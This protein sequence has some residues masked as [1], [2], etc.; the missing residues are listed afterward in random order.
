MS[1]ELG[2]VSINIDELSLPKDNIVSIILEGPDGFQE[3][4]SD[5][6]VVSDGILV[7]SINSSSSATISLYLYFNG[8]D[9]NC[10][11]IKILSFQRST[12]EFNIKLNVKENK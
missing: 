8:N 5:G 11:T 1:E 10:T 2:D 12:G 4:I 7:S 9:E 3:M 6:E